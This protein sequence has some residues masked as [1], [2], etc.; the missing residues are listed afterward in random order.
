MLIDVV[1][2][3]HE[4]DLAIL[5]HCIDGIKKNIIDVR[6]IIVVSKEK[7]TDQAEWFDEVL[8][9]FS[10]QEISNLVNGSNVGWNFQQLLKLYAPLII[11]GILPNVLVIDADT[12]FYRKTH[13]F[14][15]E[16]LPLYNL[17][18]DKN[19]ENSNFHQV[20]LRHIKK[21]LPE[22]AEKF[23]KNFENISGI[24]HH[25]LFQKHIIEELFAA[26][27]K[28][29]P[30]G[31]PFYKIFL[32]N[33]ENSFGVAE[34]NLYFYF[35]ITAH[36]H[37]YQIRILQYKNTAKFSPFKERLRRK[38][39]YCSYHSYMRDE[40]STFIKDFLKKILNKIRNLFLF[41]QWNI[42]IIGFPIQKILEKNPKII[43]LPKPPKTSFWADQFSFKIGDQKFIICED[44]SKILRRGRILIATLDHDLKLANKK[45]LLDDK[46]HLSY[47]FVFT[48]EGRIYLL[49]EAAKS[50]TLPLY[51]IDQKT[52]EAK[53]IRD[54]FTDKKVVDPTIIFYQ[55]KFWLFYTKADGAISNLNI[56]FADSL[57]DEFKRHPKNPV[58]VSRSSA[59]PAGTPFFVDEKLYRPAQNCSETYGGSIIINRVTTLNEE[60][61]AEEFVKEIKPNPSDFYNEGLHTISDFGEY[62]L[63]DGKKNIFVFYKPF[64]SLFCNLKKIFLSIRKA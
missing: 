10:Y 16:G 15:K 57:F 29:D 60:D 31:N 62:T 36:P 32:Q 3:A 8:Y 35:L 27:E 43:W 37:D 19:L 24:C 26:V 50:K 13:F 34:Y 59:R 28:R 54:I 53:K 30:A 51:E 7:F 20:T 63:I 21:I 40:T 42:G 11:P 14:S 56:A 46:K 61:F 44:Y 6:R 41:E 38:Y 49:C 12:V 9:P 33:R 64:T 23:P 48:H 58:K 47:P 25:M 22:I 45:I 55:N 4:K 39:H 17:S 1:I 2:P 18:K 5:N 52:L